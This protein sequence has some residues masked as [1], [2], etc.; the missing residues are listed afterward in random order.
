MSAFAPI[1][2]KLLN[3]SKR[4]DGTAALRYFVMFFCKTTLVTFAVQL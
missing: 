4:V 3:Y 2:T 1:A